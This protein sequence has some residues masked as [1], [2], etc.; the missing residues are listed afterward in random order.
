VSLLKYLTEGDFELRKKQSDLS[1]LSEGLQGIL[2]SIDDDP[3][4]DYPIEIKKSSWDVLDSP[5]RYRK[6]F[7]FNA[8]DS[9]MY[10]FN[11]L[12][13]YQFKIDHHCR[14]DI[15]GLNIAVETYTHDIDSLTEQDKLIKK[16]AD[17]LYED[18]NYFNSR[19]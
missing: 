13:K 10:F 2:K 15:K 1:L 3:V 6:Q 12:F 17:E 14:I 16:F 8:I 4:I 9:A 18:V 5:E 19:E 7:E 11:E